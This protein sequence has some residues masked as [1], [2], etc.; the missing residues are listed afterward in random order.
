MSDLRPPPKDSRALPGPVTASLPGVNFCIFLAGAVAARHTQIIWG[1]YLEPRLKPCLHCWLQEAFHQYITKQ[2]YFPPSPLWKSEDRPVRGCSQVAG[3]AQGSAH[4]NL[5]Q[6]C[7]SSGLQPA[8]S[9]VLQ[10]LRPHIHALNLLPRYSAGSTHSASSLLT[11]SQPPAAICCPT[12]ALT[13]PSSS[14]TNAGPLHSH[15]LARPFT[16][17]QQPFPYLGSD[18][19]Q[20]RQQQEFSESKEE[21]ELF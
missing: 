3:A 8:P 15:L 18:C 20:P 7:P 10:S 12:S 13:P 16:P 11:L 19:R 17:A 1:L 6:H 9:R 21:Q 5:S 4:P 14:S 2:H